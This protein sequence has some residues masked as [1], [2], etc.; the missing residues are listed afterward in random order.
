M[1]NLFLA[2]ITV[3]AFSVVTNAQ[4]TTPRTGTGANNDLT[5]RNLQLKYVSATDVAGADTVKLN[6]NAFLTLVKVALVDSLS[7][8]L[9]SVANSYLGDVIKITINGGTSGNKLKFVGSNY[10]YAS[11]S[12]AVSTGRKAN[13]EFVF[14]GASWQETGRATY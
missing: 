13:I 3:F 2:L 14:D 6:P 12:I 7:L 1:K 8:K 5:F 10:T 11:S 4:Y 9:P